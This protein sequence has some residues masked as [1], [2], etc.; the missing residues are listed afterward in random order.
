MI[1]RDRNRSTLTAT[2]SAAPLTGLILAGGRSTRFGSDKASA[3]VGGR[4]LLQW[5]ASAL[6]SVSGALVIV[7][8]AGQALPPFSVDIPVLV[9]EDRYEA[10][11]PLAG[12]VSGFPHVATEY[13]FA[14]SCDVPLLQ[15]ALVSYLHGLAPGHDIVC[16]YFGEFAEPLTA[17]YRPGTCLSPFERSVESGVLKIV[18]AY[19]SLDVLKVE[20]P[21]LR[22]VDPELRSFLNA[23]RP[24]ALE[25]VERL[26]HP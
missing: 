16:P 6:E 1:L 24:E 15:P 10:K 22:R 9:A 21:A 12:L 8:A 26:I 18:A 23:N 14:V 5:V 19:G 2:N 11:G 25:E 17:I 7:R 3:I 13:C 20:E 4:P